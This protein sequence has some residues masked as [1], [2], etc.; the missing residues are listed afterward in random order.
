MLVSGELRELI[1][2]DGLSGVTANPA[3]FEK[4]I[5]GSHDYDLAIRALSTEGKRADQ[6]Y[7]AIAVEDV[8]HAADLLRRTYERTCGRDGFVSLEVSPRLAH[9]TDGT[10]AEAR[11]F[12]AAFDRP[13]V[14]IKVPAT[15]EGL[16]AIRQLTGEGINVNITLLFGLPRYREV[17]DAYVTGLEERLARGYSVTQIQSVASFFLSRIDVLVDPLL[18]KLMQDGGA[19]AELAAAIHG[20]LAVSSAK[21]AYQIYREV[22]E[23][24]GR[25]R[26]VAR[27]GAHTQRLLWAST[28]TKNPAYSDVKYVEPLIGPDTVNTMPLETIQAYRDHGQPALTLTEDVALARRVLAQ[29]GETGIDIDQITQQLEDEGVRKFDVALDQLLVTLENKRYETLSMH[30]KSSGFSSRTQADWRITKCV[31]S[32]TVRRATSS[33]ARS[34]IRISAAVCP[35]SCAG[36]CTVVSDGVTSTTMGTS[37]KPTTAISSGARR[38]SSRKAARPPKA[39]RSLPAKTAVGRSSNPR[40]ACMT[41]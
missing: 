36:K 23:Q 11:R 38:P 6:I 9:D 16:P 15:R 2:G 27:R 31:S 30:G 41:L 21:V 26:A 10:I 20:V 13:N 4:A 14:L 40:S 33:P 34:C 25:F 18:E 17:I 28:G 8:G 37:S 24:G 1:Y 12:W 35:R 39:T 7:E 22:F 5:D 32:N 19:K 3:I 29:L